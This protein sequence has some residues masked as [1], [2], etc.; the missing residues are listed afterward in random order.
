M[1]DFLRGEEPA[2]IAKTEGKARRRSSVTSVSSRTSKNSKKEEVELSVNEEVEE[3][4]QVD[5]DAL[6]IPQTVL[7]K[8]NSKNGKDMDEQETVKF[9]K[10]IDLNDE[11]IDRMYRISYLFYD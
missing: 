5:K 8:N 3:D 4:W 11:E 10:S 7:F 9:F 2:V 6:K 1:K